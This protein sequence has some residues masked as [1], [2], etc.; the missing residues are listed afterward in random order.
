M[1]REHLTGIDLPQLAAKPA[2]PAAGKIRVYARNDGKSYKQLP[3]GTET[4]L[5]AGGG[6]GGSAARSFFFA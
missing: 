5:G 3:D 4:E 2:A 1:A 6:G